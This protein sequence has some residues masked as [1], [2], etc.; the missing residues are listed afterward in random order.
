MYLLVQHDLR[1]VKCT[2]LVIVIAVD[3]DG[4]IGKLQGSLVDLFPEAGMDS[5]VLRLG[6]VGVHSADRC[7]AQSAV[8]LYLRYH[9][10]E[11]INVC[12][13]HHGI[14]FVLA[15]KRYQHAAL[16]G[17]LRLITE[18]L[19]RFHHIIRHICGISARAVDCQ[20]LLCLLDHIF[21]I[22]FCLHLF[23]PFPLSI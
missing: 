2:L 11:R 5:A 14:L 19:V 21:H 6:I 23:S 9:G 8:G 4:C 1:L 17:Q 18:L 10:A 13:E 3:M 15:A 7:H 12:L 22:F 20:N 16:C